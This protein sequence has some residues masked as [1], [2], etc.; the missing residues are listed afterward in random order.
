MY[1]PVFVVCGRASRSAHAH[2]TTWIVKLCLC[3]DP[4]LKSV[5]LTNFNENL[6]TQFLLTGFNQKDQGLYIPFDIAFCDIATN[7]KLSFQI[8]VKVCVFCDFWQDKITLPER[9]QSA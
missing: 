1:R 3:Y 5:N 6:E 4:R 7:K 9:D 2:Y 8:F